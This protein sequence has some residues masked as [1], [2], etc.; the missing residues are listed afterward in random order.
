M[1]VIGRKKRKNEKKVQK[2]RVDNGTA[3]ELQ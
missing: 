2:L 1:R 3:V